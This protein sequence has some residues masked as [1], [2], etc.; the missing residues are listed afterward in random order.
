MARLLRVI[1]ELVILIKG[2]LVS[3][4]SVGTTL[5]LLGIFLYVFGIA[6]TQLCKN[7]EV[8]SDRFPTVFASM[9][10]LLLYGVLCL[11]YVEDVARGLTAVHPLVSAL[12]FMFVLL[13]AFTVMNMLIGV[14]CEVVSQVAAVEKEQTAVM[15]AK[16]TLRRIL[17]ELDDDDNMMISRNE[18]VQLIANPEAC[19]ALHELGVD[20][21]GLIESA[22]VIFEVDN[23]ADDDDDEIE[24]EFD[25]FIEIIMQ[26][27]GSSTSTVRDIVE[28]RRCCRQ[29]STETQA[30]L[31]SLSGQVDNLAVQVNFD[32]TPAGSR[33]GSRRPSFQAGQTSRKDLIKQGMEMDQI[34]QGMAREQQLLLK[35]FNEKL[36]RMLTASGSGIE[37]ASC[38]TNSNETIEILDAFPEKQVSRSLSRVSGISNSAEKQVSRSLSR[39]SGIS[40]G[41]DSVSSEITTHEV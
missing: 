32:A 24:L 31:T 12:Y 29:M 22:D 35:N 38:R 6:F 23:V 9:Y 19:I 26:L 27:R 40:D 7:T 36:P 13:T 21:L 16:I 39:V 10:S 20:V 17:Q 4:R 37:M 15:T 33:T 8:G 18:F 1:P 25:E 30:M 11:D 34:K 5:G 14:L 3:T 28:L 41:D 2:M